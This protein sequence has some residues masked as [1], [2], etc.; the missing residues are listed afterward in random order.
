MRPPAADVQVNPSA[1]KYSPL[2]GQL[3]SCKQAIW[4][5]AV[6]AGLLAFTPL[7]RVGVQE[8]QESAPLFLPPNGAKLGSRWFGT[9]SVHLHQN[10]KISDEVTPITTRAEGFSAKMSHTDIYLYRYISFF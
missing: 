10:L 9:L 5:E 2:V 7:R 1:H 3:Q 4:A 6:G 8:V